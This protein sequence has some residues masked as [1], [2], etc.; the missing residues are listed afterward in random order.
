MASLADTMPG[1]RLPEAE[2]DGNGTQDRSFKSKTDT[3]KER[4]GTNIPERSYEVLRLFQE[5]SL[6]QLPVKA[7][8]L[9]CRIDTQ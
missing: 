4:P 5:L 6:E 8:N 9:D 3:K 2:V 1:M 7:T